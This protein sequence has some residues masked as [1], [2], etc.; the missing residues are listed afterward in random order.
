MLY[1]VVSKKKKFAELSVTFRDALQFPETCR[2][3][4]LLKKNCQ[5]A[6]TQIFSI[7]FQH[8]FIMVFKYQAE[9]VRT[10]WLN[11]LIIILISSK[12]LT[13]YTGA[14]NDFQ[15]ICH[16]SI[17]YCLNFYNYFFSESNGFA[18]FRA[19]GARNSQNHYCHR[20]CFYFGPE[21]IN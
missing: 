8:L 12:L 7:N 6:E 18:N 2:K 20:V 15:F 1:W 4:G 17:Y 10:F 3:K 21:N 5:D 19:Y 16:S 9:W 13:M 14:K 11:E